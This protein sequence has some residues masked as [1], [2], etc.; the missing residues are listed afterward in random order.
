[1]MHWGRNMRM[2]SKIVIPVG[3]ML[4]LALGVLTWQVQSKAG[5]AFRRAAQ[6]ELAGMA[7]LYGNEVGNILE[8]ALDKGGALASAFG[9]SVESGRPFSRF[10]VVTAVRGVQRDDKSIAAIGVAFEPDALDGS[11]SRHS[12]YTGSDDS[13]RFLPYVISGE[14]EVALLEGTESGDWYLEPKRTRKA[15]LTEPYL[16]PMG[17]KNVLMTTAS[18]PILADGKFLGM[19]G[20]DIS[21]DRIANIV[22]N[23]KIYETGGGAVITGNGAIVAHKNAKLLNT[24]IFDAGLVGDSAALKRAIRNGEPYTE[25][26][27]FQGRSSIFYYYPIVFA[28][29]GQTWYMGISAPVSEVL[30]EVADIRLVT[31][32][33]SSIVLLLA[34]VLIVAIVRSVVKPLGV[35]A[36]TAK[37]IAAGNLRVAIE[38]EKFGGEIRDLSVSLKEMITSLLENINKAEDMSKDALAQTERAKE[39]MLEADNARA[40]AES[41]KREGMLAAAQRLESVV[42]VVAEASRELS[43]Q[44]ESS[45]KGSEEQASLV[46]ETVSAMD[47]MNRTVMDVARNAG[48][49]SELSAEARAKAE[50]G[51]AIVRQA[52][53]DIQNVQSVSLALKDDMTH[54][55]EQAKAITNIM[56]VISDIADQTNLLALNAAIEAARAGEAGRGFAVVA[57]EV[58]KL[59]EKTMISTKDV[60]D[61]VNA[62]QQSVDRSILQVER[63]VELIGV[64]TEQSGKSGTALNEIVLMVDNSADQVRAIAAASE[65]QSATSEE[66]TRS[67]GHVNSIAEETARTMSRAAD[68]VAGLSR[69]TEELNA[70]IDEM[71]KA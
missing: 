24:N 52:V 31:I 55:A 66:I 25:I 35:L 5:D 40:A 68:A 32:V 70:L 42:N 30:A 46:H 16:Y 54:L 17:G 58:R 13:G 50:E 7:G 61:S 57:D 49:A 20:V 28:D 4:T 45:D 34:L 37:E 3:I 22:A 2:T 19:V 65:E 15:Y 11:D 59:A 18:S 64:A 41:A 67:I 38:D 33:I 8:A 10:N 23:L 51:A 36:G 9:N 44:I 12:G 56:S 26:N 47:E 60:G 48:T 1:M 14:R 53:T 69:Q 27:A 63:A 43:V 62:I 29:T 39:A 71:K 21:L 6:R